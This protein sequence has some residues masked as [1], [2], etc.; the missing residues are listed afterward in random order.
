[1]RDMILWG[2]HPKHQAVPIKLELCTPESYARRGKEGWILAVHEPGIPPR[3]LWR[4]TT[5]AILSK[6]RLTPNDVV[7]LLEIYHQADGQGPTA[8]GI[9]PAI[10]SLRAVS[11]LALLWKQMRDERAVAEG[12]RPNPSPARRR[13]RRRRRP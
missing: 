13:A 3:G 1:M 7:D 2:Y 6:P 4:K 10:G 12:A 11:T 5:E 9:R 8:E